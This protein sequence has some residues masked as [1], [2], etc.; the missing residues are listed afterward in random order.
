ML[1][2]AYLRAAPPKSTGRDL[3]NPVWL[4]G[5]LAHFADVAAV[6]VQATLTEFTATALAKAMQVY[7][8]AGSSLRVCGGGA[9]NGWLMQRLAALLPGVSV[10]STSSVGIDPLQVEATAFAWLAHKAVQR[11]KL[12]LKSITGAR[13]ARVLGC[14]YPA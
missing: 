11:Q 6:D 14:I 8:R 7:G 1:D 10:E 9:L 13:G 12:D 5:K 2:E 3:F 4:A